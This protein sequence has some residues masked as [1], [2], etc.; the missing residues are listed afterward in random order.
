MSSAPVTDE[1]EAYASTAERY[2]LPGQPFRPVAAR[3]RRRPD[4]V[5]VNVALF[6]LTVAST[7]VLGATHY[8]LFLTDF[9]RTPLSLSPWSWSAL[10]AGLAYS[11]AILG[12]LGVHE[13]GHYLA[14][15]YYG[16]DASLPYFLPAP[17]MTGTLGAFIRIRSPIY[18]KAVLFDVGIAGPLAGF[19]VAVPVLI[20]GLALSNVAPLPPNFQGYEL[21]EPLLF[22]A[23]AY[24]L[25]GAVPGGHSLNLHPAAFA[26]WF[27]L[28]AT[29]LNL[30]P[31]GQLDGGH[32]IYAVFGRR[33]I[34][35]SGVAICA[36]VG[37]IFVSI[38]WLAWTVLML[39]LL[40]AFGP[41]HPP[42]VD[43]DVPL[44]GRRKAL[45]CAALLVFV[46]CF[47]PA[48]IQPFELIR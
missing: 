44:D 38:S 48:P 19:L 28:L 4:R 42:T 39:A 18:A 34:W 41:K 47:T 15:R 43:E 5:W 24:L 3:V 37:L 45:A 2:Q 36:A 33:A 17:G 46:A 32:I 8:S 7:T 11:G 31:I 20:V 25:W 1:A 10:A 13:L 35:V 14:C 26:A 12:I 23:L 27:G 6:V 30:F 9:G 29:A 16:I 40:V 22:Q 21:G